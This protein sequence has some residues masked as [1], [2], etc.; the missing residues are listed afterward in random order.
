MYACVYMDR[1]S[2]TFNKN[3]SNLCSV[4]LCKIFTTKS[5]LLT[6]LRKITFENIV[7][8]KCWLPAFFPFSMI[9][10]NLL[11][12][13]LNFWVTFILSSANAFN[14]DQSNI[15]SFGKELSVSYKR[16]KL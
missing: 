2:K 1:M 11:K 12:T 10:S 8:K 13:N 14:L 16:P 9:F 15:L 7:G 3:K 5:R 6:T 4:E